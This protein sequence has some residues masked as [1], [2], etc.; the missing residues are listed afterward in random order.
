MH[1]SCIESMICTKLLLKNSKKIE[2][3]NGNTS[4]HYAF[5]LERINIYIKINIFYIK[6]FI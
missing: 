3:N 2:D 1:I 4:E 5:F 6:E